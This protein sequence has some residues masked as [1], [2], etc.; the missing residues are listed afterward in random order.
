MVRKS[1]E[2]VVTEKCS[3]GNRV[4]GREGVMNGYG[5]KREMRWR[6]RGGEVRGERV[7]IEKIRSRVEVKMNCKMEQRR[8]IE[9]KE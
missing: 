2:G 5:V 1:H 9:I 6:R 4:V 7:G 8:D 3:E